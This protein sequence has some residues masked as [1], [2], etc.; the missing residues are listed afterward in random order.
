MAHTVEDLS[1]KAGRPHWHAPAPAA[2]A[3]AT[4]LFGWR[5]ERTS[6]I[7]AV[8]A[9][10]PAIAAALAAPALLTTTEIVDL[11][12][13]IAD[14][15]AL[16]AGDGEVLKSSS[17]FYLAMLSAAD[18]IF[19]TPGRILL[20]AKAL[21]ALIAATAVIAIAC[22]R[23]PFAQTALL[24]ASTAAFVA[25]PFSGVNET[26]LALLAAA[27]IAFVCAPAQSSKTR[28][29]AEGAL[30]GGVLATLWMS[31][32]ALA[33]IGAVALTAC[34]FISGRGGFLRYAAAILV[35]GGLIASFEL[36]FPGSI[37]AR[38]ET[39]TST[40][41]SLRDHRIS[42]STF[43][44]T[45]IGLGACF[46][47]V[48]AAVFGGATYRGNVWTALAFLLFGAAGAAMV[49]ANASLV[50]VFSAAI[51][52]FSTSSPFYDGIFRA[53][54]RASVAISGAVGVIA[55]GLGALICM[56]A[57]EQFV[58][59]ARSTAP[60]SEKNASPFAI[61]KLTQKSNSHWIDDG[62]IIERE[63][64][65]DESP[66]ASDQARLLLNVAARVRTLDAAGFK[67]AILANSDIACVI[68]GN[69][70]CSADGR[71]AAARANV[72]ISPRLSLGAGGVSTKE[73][74]E[75]LLY[76]EFRRIEETPQWDL[77]VRRDVSLPNY[78]LGS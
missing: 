31:S 36:L 26:L 9:A 1:N 28:A 4:A 55:L 45:E 14:A 19:A 58:L 77:W 75:G 30:G 52:V 3:A 34:P 72:V 37:V 25:A 29:L 40:V 27:A 50:F 15:R 54:D 71:T 22:V 76:S 60:A 47:L 68:V 78:D 53:H 74:L 8:A 5:D 51:A 62:R 17:L 6:V 7:A 38:A 61:T 39:V 2:R 18:S 73:R 48:L 33:L 69:N 16:A 56:Q 49:G 57:A 32:P 23:F 13:P 35:V 59:Q 42:T 20:G 46:V 41:N 63:L 65:P 67:V 70:D 64:T 10:A 11:I 12:G 24:A 21:S 66:E 43:A 44:S